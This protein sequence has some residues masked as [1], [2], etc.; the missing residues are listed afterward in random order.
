MNLPSMTQNA[1]TKGWIT[2]LAALVAGGGHN[3]ALVNTAHCLQRGGR[4]SP[5]LAS[6]GVGGVHE[7]FTPPVLMTIA[8]GSPMDP[9]VLD[10]RQVAPWRRQTPWCSRQRPP[11]TSMRIGPSPG[12]SVV[13]PYGVDTGEIRNYGQMVSRTCT[14]RG[15]GRCQARGPG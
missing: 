11:V 12:H 6:D 2:E 9:G 15:R 8:F 1:S 10:A 7:S 4:R 3:V 13:V 5:P 14:A